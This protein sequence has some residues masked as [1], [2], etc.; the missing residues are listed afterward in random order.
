MDD[1]AIA[2]INTLAQKLGTTAEHM[3]AVLVRQAP[4]DGV[5]RLAVLLGLT[6]FTVCLIRFVRAKTKVPPVTETDRY[7]RAEWSD[8][9]AVLFAWLMA[10]FVAAIYVVVFVAQLPDIAAAFF[11]PEYWALKQ[12]F[13]LR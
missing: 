3:F 2:L 10:V 8:A 12:I 6:V 7:P 4:I 1:K 5:A 9:A 13:S 11:N